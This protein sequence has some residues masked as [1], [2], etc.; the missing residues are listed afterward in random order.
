ICVVAQLVLVVLVGLKVVRVLKAEIK[1]A[2]GG[3]D[4]EERMDLRKLP[5]G[6][7]VDWVDLPRDLKVAGRDLEMFVAE[8][9]EVDH[10]I[11]PSSRTRM[12]APDGAGA[13]QAHYLIVL[14]LRVTCSGV[15]TG[16]FRWCEVSSLD[17]SG[18]S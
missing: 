16:R 9:M 17:R 4:S 5:G 7:G 13:A 14:N 1:G 8:T 10:R 15:P 3:R 2:D 11:V 18:G 6:G 12:R